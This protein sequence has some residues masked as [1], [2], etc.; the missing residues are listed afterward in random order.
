M[1]MY[2]A[3]DSVIDSLDWAQLGNPLIL[4]RFAHATA[5]SCSLA[6]LILA[7]LSHVSGSFS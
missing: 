6:L 5:V 4:A 1:K 7:G 2:L 3:L